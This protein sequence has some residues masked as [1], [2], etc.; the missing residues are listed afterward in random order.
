MDSGWLG[1]AKG[2]GGVGGNIAGAWATDGVS[3]I[4]PASVL[5]TGRSW[6][7][8]FDSRVFMAS[9]VDFRICSADWVRDE[10]S[11][12]KACLALSMRFRQR[13]EQVLA[14]SLPLKTML[15]PGQILF[16]CRAIFLKYFYLAKA[17]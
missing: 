3:P 13:A 14:V 8:M 17:N 7:E 11:R 6:V 5:A 15:Q 1:P 12:A 16:F 4:N 10:A 9:S 2:P